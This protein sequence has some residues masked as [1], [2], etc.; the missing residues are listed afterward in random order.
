MQ[1]NWQPIETAKKIPGKEILG[2]RW[3]DGI[4]KKEPFVT[5]WSPSL[6]KFFVDPT[7]WV[8]MPDPPKNAGP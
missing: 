3:H 1:D 7:H 5:F 8:E 6:N 4:M 2:C